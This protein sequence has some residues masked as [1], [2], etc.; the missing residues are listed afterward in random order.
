MT[1]DVMTTRKL[2]KK[3]KIKLPGDIYDFLKQYA[4]SKQE[5]FIVATL[6]GACEVIA[7]H[8]ASIGLVNRVIIHP[9]EVFRHA[10]ADNASA[11]IVAHNHPSENIQ[12]SPEDEEI[13]RRLNEAAKVVG[14]NFVDHLIITKYCYY[15]FRQ[16]KK[17]ED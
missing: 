13:T 12:P 15:S 7:V 16:E 9:R 5:H 11:V 4:K 1:Y 10:I 2:R 6:N 3:I 8:I 17:L 14:I